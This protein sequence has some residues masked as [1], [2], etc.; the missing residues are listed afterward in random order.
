MSSRATRLTGL[1]AV[2]AA[3]LLSLLA[4]AYFATEAGA[5]ELANARPAGAQQLPQRFTIY[6]A[7]IANKDAPWLVEATGP[8][9]G[10]GLVTAG[11]APGN[12]APLTLAL[13]KGKVFL[14]ARGDF[15]WKPDF[16]TC[17]A[18]RD[19]R[20]TYTITGG[21]SAYR[22]AAG[23][24][25]LSEHGAGIGVRSS[26]GKCLQKFKVNYVTVVLTGRA[27]ARTS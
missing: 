12:T 1:Y 26:S 24:G 19:I 27:S 16:A 8:I 25:T 20:G 23:K 4:L 22:S 10:V 18:T 2:I 9:S 13:P 6:T 14:S 7:T 17:T 15:R 11:A 21:T 3:V 5:E